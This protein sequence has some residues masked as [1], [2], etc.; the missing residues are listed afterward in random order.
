[1]HVGADRA[2]V[3][4]LLVPVLQRAALSARRRLRTSQPRHAHDCRRTAAGRLQVP[5]SSSL[6]VMT[7]LRVACGDC[8][9]LVHLLQTFPGVPPILSLVLYSRARTYTVHPWSLGYLDTA[10]AKALPNIKDSN[11]VMYR[12]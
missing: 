4:R 7:E 6:T 2:A 9:K 8:G 5:S 11:C 3:R 1:V 12:P 10:R